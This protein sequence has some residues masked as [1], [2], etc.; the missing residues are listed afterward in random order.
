M[1][2]GIMFYEIGRGGDRGNVF[3]QIH[4]NEKV[5]SYIGIPIMGLQLWDSFCDIAIWGMDL[6]KNFTQSHP[7]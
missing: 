2:F 6:Y 4:F 1:N 5:D 7:H 3:A